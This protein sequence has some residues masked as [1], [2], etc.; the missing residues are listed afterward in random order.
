MFAGMKAFAF[1]LVLLATEVRRLHAHATPP[2]ADPS[3]LSLTPPVTH[4]RH[5]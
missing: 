4:P 1:A 3:L 5:L 2:L